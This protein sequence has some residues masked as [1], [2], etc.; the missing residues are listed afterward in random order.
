MKRILPLL[1]L[2]LIGTFRA[3]SQEPPILFNLIFASNAPPH[4]A[5]VP[6]GG[7]VLETNSFSGIVYFDNTPPVSGQILE[8]QDDNSF[9]MI[10][11]MN[12]V[13]A[14]YPPAM[15][16]PG[17]TAYDLERSF[18]PVNDLQVQNLLDG[19]WYAEVV[20][21]ENTYLGQFIPVPEASSAT[22]MACGI[23]LLLT[24]RRFRNAA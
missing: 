24:R 11:S 18:L 14:A 1:I 9:Q 10:S 13:F 23:S 12:I 6:P 22:L 5:F 19:K 8:R 3:W 17:G 16:S 15:G 7:G 4:A 20:L 2:V 21:G